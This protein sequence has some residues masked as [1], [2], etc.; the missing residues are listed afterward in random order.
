[1]KSTKQ[2]FTR[3]AIALSVV[4]A[5][6]GFNWWRHPSL[7][8]GVVLPPGARVVYS[9]RLLNPLLSGPALYYCIE[10]PLSQR[11]T[12]AFLNRGSEPLRFVSAEAMKKHDFADSLRGESGDRALVFEMHDQIFATETETSAQCRV[13]KKANGSTA[14]IPVWTNF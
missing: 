10:S 1:M 9:V 6:F 8:Q 5:A 2:L 3:A 11:A 4:L 14:E 7:G 13:W 12:A